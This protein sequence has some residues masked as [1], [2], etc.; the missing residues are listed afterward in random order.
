MSDLALVLLIMLGMLSILLI[1]VYLLSDEHLDREQEKIIK[2]AFR[3]R[4]GD[5]YE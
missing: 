3:E 2:E 4:I 1:L 5:D